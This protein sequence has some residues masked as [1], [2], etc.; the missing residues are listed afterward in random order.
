MI[1]L[2]VPCIG[3]Y[4]LKYRC[5]ETW[6]S[7]T[8]SD[9]P[10]TASPIACL[11]PGTYGIP[12]PRHKPDAKVCQQR[13]NELCTLVRNDRRKKTKIIFFYFNID[14]T[15]TKILG[16]F[17]WFNFCSYWFGKTF[18]FFLNRN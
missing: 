8:A 6:A 2:V 17:S 3:F 5:I 18:L 9:W 15:Y 11:T 1:S 13:F 10:N 4:I 16:R 14:G 12:V 7:P